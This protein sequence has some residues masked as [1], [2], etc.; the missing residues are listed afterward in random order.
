M[1]NSLLNV[2]SNIPNS[3]WMSLFLTACLV[4]APIV[5]PLSFGQ[6]YENWCL[7][8]F[9]NLHN[10]QTYSLS[11]QVLKRDPRLV[12]Y[13]IVRTFLPTPHSINNVNPKTLE[14]IYLLMSRKLVNFFRYIVKYISKVSSVSR[15]VPLPYAHM[16]TLIFKHFLFALQMR[17]EKLDLFLSLA[18]TSL[19][20]SISLKLIW[21]PRNSLM[22]W[23]QQ[24][25][26]FPVKWVEL[27]PLSV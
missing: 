7:A 26:L 17:F 22:K 8:E 2:E 5:Q 21:V 14:A 4:Y 24:N 12:Y 16:L 15:P 10:T 18:F 23:P 1:L 6:E 13:V 19:N 9:A 3:L 20:L 27:S 11:Y 25:K